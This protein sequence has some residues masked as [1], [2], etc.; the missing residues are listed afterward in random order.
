EECL[1]DLRID[2]LFQ[3]IDGLE[4]GDTRLGNQCFEFDHKVIN[5]HSTLFQVLDPLTC[6]IMF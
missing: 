2:V 6:I 3:E 5:L 4:I 1:D